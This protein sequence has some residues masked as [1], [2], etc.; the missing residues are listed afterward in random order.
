MKVRV[1]HNKDNLYCIYSKEL[2]EIGERY[3]EVVENYLGEEILKTYKYFCLDMLV[4]ESIENYDE[5][6]IIEEDYE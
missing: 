2:I 5:D 6:V 3:I 1:N 4:D